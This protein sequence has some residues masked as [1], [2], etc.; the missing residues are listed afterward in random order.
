MSNDTKFKKNDI[1]YY[2]DHLGDYKKAKFEAPSLDGVSYWIKDCVRGYITNVLA[3]SVISPE[4]YRNR[5]LVYR[6][7]HTVRMADEKDAIEKINKE[8]ETLPVPGR[9]EKVKVI[10]IVEKS[11]G[12]IISKHDLQISAENWIA[13]SHHPAQ[14]T[15]Y[16]LVELEEIRVIKEV[17]VHGRNGAQIQAPP[18]S[19]TF[20]NGCEW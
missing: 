11:T 13:H 8:L 12:K 4:E 1:V 19:N 17:T 16:E 15:I 18:N 5:L 7:A 6:I 10:A 3:A 9:T 20:P 2:Q 14:N